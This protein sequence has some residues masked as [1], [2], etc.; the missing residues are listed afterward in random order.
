M[1]GFHLYLVHDPNINNQDTQP[2]PTSP[3]T[4]SSLHPLQ[5]IFFSFFLSLY[6]FFPCFFFSLFHSYR[7]SCLYFLHL[8][9][10]SSLPILADTFLPHIYRQR[11][12]SSSSSLVNLDPLQV[13]PI[14][15]FIYPTPLWC[16][17]S[18]QTLLPNNY[19]K[20]IP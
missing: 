12:P 17:L 9:S 18:G 10:L 16:P 1:I 4:S 15:N 7:F 6:S 3:V 14:P 20:P 13:S 19:S 8:C 5:P 2:M 11:D